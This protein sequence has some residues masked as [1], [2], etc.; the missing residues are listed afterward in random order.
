MVSQANRAG[1]LAFLL[2]TI[3]FTAASVA[4]TAAADDAP[5]AEG[6]A[7]TAAPVAHEP[8]PLFDDEFDLELDDQPLGF[9]DPMEGLNR[10]ILIFNRGFTDYVLDPLT[11]V[12]R[13]ILPEGGRDAV[14]RFFL[15]LGG[16]AVFVNDVLQGE[17]TDAGTTLGRLFLNTTFGVAGLFDA[18]EHM[19]YAR[20]HADFG[21]TLA[22][23]GVGSGPYLLL[24][25]LGPSTMRDGAGT[26]I[27]SAFHPTTYFLGPTQRLFLGGSSGLATLEAHFDA[28][29]ALE[30]SSLDYYAALRNAYYQRRIDEIWGR[31]GGPPDTAHLGGVGERPARVASDD[32]EAVS[33]PCSPR[34][35][36]SYFRGSRSPHRD[37]CDRTRSSILHVVAQAR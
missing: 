34:G 16:S 14:Q 28:M 29:R 18:A 9:P 13:F 33:F 3:L 10:K 6:A 15:N 8:D 19:G 27:D 37:R 25:V 20:H 30:E 11:R 24:P 31:H 22:R 26:V 12:Y 2:A 17:G 5:S 35:R 7:A 1:T 32:G 4:P 23:Y 21:Q 36:R